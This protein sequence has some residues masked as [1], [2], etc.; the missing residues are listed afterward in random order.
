MKIHF[1]DNLYYQQA[2][3][4]SVMSLFKREDIDR[5]LRLV[6]KSILVLL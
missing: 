2:T 4:S 5:N 1:E 3:I 6:S